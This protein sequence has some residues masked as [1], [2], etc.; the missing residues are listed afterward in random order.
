ME[1]FDE[2]QRSW[3][4]NKKQVLENVAMDNEHVKQIIAPRIKRERNKIFGYFWGSCFWQF[5]IYASLCHLLIRFWGDREIGLISLAGIV[6]Y[7]P[8]TTVFIR[9]Y[10][11]M[12]R[13]KST[14]SAESI[15]DHLQKQYVLLVEFFQFKKKFDW[16]GIPI[17]CFILT[18][19]VFKLWVPN[20]AMQ[21][22]TVAAITYLCTLIA[23]VVATVSENKK[24][25]QQ[26][27][28]GLQQVMKD[29]KQ[30]ID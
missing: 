5:A 13:Q 19:M 8:F 30:N 6:L 16:I 29:L 4:L 25:F 22:L 27:I 3:A 24:S 20:G 10:S 21:H 26:P 17:T 23:F 1:T 18:A 7:I 15:C 28:E 12:A 2:M 14:S 9:K 11:R